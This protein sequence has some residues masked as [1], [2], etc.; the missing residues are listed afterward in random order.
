MKQ[1]SLPLVMGLLVS[2]G[3]R[4]IPGQDV[5]YEPTPMLVVRAMLELADVGPQDV[6]YDLGSGD[7]RIPITAAK[8]F[9]ARGVGIE[10]DPTL[11]RQAQANA[12]KAGVADKVEFRLGDMYVADVRPATV[13]TLFL[14]PKP[15]LKLRPKL[16]SE[17]QPGSRVVSYAWNMADWAPDEA[18][19]VNAQRIFLWRIPHRAALIIGAQ[20]SRQLQRVEVEHD[21]DVKDPTERRHVSACFET[22]FWHREAPLGNERERMGAG[23]G[24]I[25]YASRQPSHRSG[26]FRPPVSWQVPPRFGLG[27]MLDSLPAHDAREPTGEVARHHWTR[28]IGCGVTERVRSSSS[29]TSMAF[30]S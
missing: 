22:E 4:T 18:R 19:R 7:G 13:V 27:S 16:R 21:I 1:I 8:E 2:F 24:S 17:L 28:G 5:R 14:H 15:N 10:I 11:V 30:S 25:S 23:V 9:G 29:T 6:V 20:L 26:W 12:R 3:C